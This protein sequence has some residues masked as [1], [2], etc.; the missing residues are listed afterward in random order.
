MKLLHTADLHLDSPFAASDIFTAEDRRAEQRALLGRIFDLAKSEKCDMI[1]IAGDLFDG[2]Y[3]TPE[4]SSYVKALFAEAGVPVIIAPGNHDPY[5][6][7][8]FYKDGELPENVYVFSSSELQRF[9]LPELRVSVF[10]YA[11][12]SSVLSESPLGGQNEAEDNGYTRLLCAHADLSAPISR[13]CPLNTADI[14]EL[15]I[16]YAA[17]GHIHNRDTDDSFGGSVIRYCGFPEGRSFDELGDGGVIIAEIDENGVSLSRKCVSAQR[18][19]LCELDVSRLSERAEIISKIKEVAKNAAA[20]K[21]THLR[22]TLTGVA[23]ADE[24]RDLSYIEAELA[25]G[26][27]LSLELINE[28][29]P[30]ADIS[31]LQADVSL[32][33]EFYRT[34]YSGLTCGDPD[35]RRR[36]ALALQ[37]GLAAIEG[38]RITGGKDEI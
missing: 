9:D 30:V 28:T 32:R 10:G 37:I 34:L 35:Q 25:G 20:D 15:G 7:G 3:V 5:V 14:A 36:T 13:Y 24:L 18:Y 16:A 31:A 29:V 12:T 4:T 27:L 6:S 33:G 11:F 22:L 21:P 23:D 38:R 1:L 17:L 2:K 26:K 8:S 19:S